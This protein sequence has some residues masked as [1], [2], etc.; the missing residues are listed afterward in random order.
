MGWTHI[1]KAGGARPPQGTLAPLDF[2]KATC[3]WH[4]VT[5]MPPYILEKSW[6]AP[7]ATFSVYS[8]VEGHLLGSTVCAYLLKFLWFVEVGNLS[9]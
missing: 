7:L 1:C 5:P 4:T 8:P 9:T 6:F 2:W 3:L